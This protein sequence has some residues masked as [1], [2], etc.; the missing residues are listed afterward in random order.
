[1]NE[2]LQH[3]GVPGMKWGVRRDA[4]VLANRR[5][6]KNVKKI[7]DLYDKGKISKEQK[8]SDIKKANTNR[9]TYVK[10]VN[11][12]LKGVK[13]ETEF[14]KVKSNIAAQAINEVPHR[15]LK[16]GATTVNKVLG[17]VHTTAN[18]AS[19][20]VLTAAAPQFGALYL[21]S[22]AINAAVE[23]GAHALVQLGI[24]KLT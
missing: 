3:Y 17:A 11:E 8:R 15:R 12:Q 6:N 10:S 4:R 9:K 5:R 22:A 21:S 16:K 24:D 20:I 23:V 2:E 18:V 1:M 13:N 7:K 19:G 14:R